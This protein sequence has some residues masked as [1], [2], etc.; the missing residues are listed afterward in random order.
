VSSCVAPSVAIISFFHTF[1]QHDVVVPFVFFPLSPIPP[2]MQ[3]Y[4][5]T[6]LLSVVLVFYRS[7]YVS[8]FPGAP[9][10]VEISLKL[11]QDF[12]RYY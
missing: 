4:T 10:L 11:M 2:A 6:L 3:E 9:L 5:A 8:S 7:L 1:P 12:V